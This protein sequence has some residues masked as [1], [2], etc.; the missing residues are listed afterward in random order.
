[1][2]N[3]QVFRDAELD[4]KNGAQLQQ[5]ALQI[6]Q[7]FDQKRG[8]YHQFRNQAVMSDRWDELNEKIIDFDNS[9][10][11]PWNQK[12]NNLQ[13]SNDINQL[14]T[15]FKEGLGL[16]SEMDE[17][18]SGIRLGQSN[19]EDV[20]ALKNDV[21]K[22]IENDILNL[23]ADISVQIEE[24]IKDL[25]GL[26]AEMGLQRNFQSNIETE[27]KKSTIYRNGFLVFFVLSIVSIPSFLASTFILTQFKALPYA[28]LMFLR[29]GVTISAAVLSYFFYSQYRLYQLICLRY[30]HLHGFLGGGATFINQI[31]GSEDDTKSDINRKMAELFMELDDVFGLVKRNQHPVEMSLDKAGEV[32]DKVGDLTSKVSNG[33]TNQVS[34]TK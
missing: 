27:L 33:L 28:E 15:Y 24:G 21:L 31:I 26:K 34:G 29:A 8:R 17:F 7:R 32:I 30:S 22:T 11:T 9:K 18:V 19:S 5:A 4:G 23:K 10:F 14:K 13:R 2:S 20:E 16:F 3:H 12:W 25:V 6:K 1:M